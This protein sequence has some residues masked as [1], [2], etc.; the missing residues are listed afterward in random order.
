[1]STV[2]E[3]DERYNFDEADR[4]RRALRVAD[5]SVNE[6][7]DYLEVS[8]NAV[9][10]WIN[11]RHLPRDRDLKRFALRTGFDICWLK[12]G[13]PPQDTDDGGKVLLTP[14]RLLTLE[15]AA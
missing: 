14:F 15:A 13:E 6:M 5:V 3:F 1:M 2:V 11:G 9:T 12:T 4:L 7:A 8:R 10:S